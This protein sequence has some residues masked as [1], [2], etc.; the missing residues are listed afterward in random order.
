MKTINEI[1]NMSNISAKEANEF[2]ITYGF[3]VVNNFN[4]YELCHYADGIHGYIIDECEADNDDEALLK[5]LKAAIEYAED[6]KLEVR[7]AEEYELGT[8]EYIINELAKFLRDET[9]E[10]CPINIVSREDVEGEDAELVRFTFGENEYTCVAVVYEDGTVYTPYDWQDTEWDKEGWKI[11]DT[12][13][14]M[15][16]YFRPCVIF[17][18]MP[19]MF[20]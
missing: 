7:E 9:I 10:E 11:S 17:N 5:L 12:K 6:E 15:D 4:K 1:K 8:D 13:R 20:V 18:E 16:C 19:R 3:E 14:W 2:L